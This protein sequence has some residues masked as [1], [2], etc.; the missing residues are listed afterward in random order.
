MLNH[1]LT[2][3]VNLHDFQDMVKDGNSETEIVWPKMFWIDRTLHNC[4]FIQFGNDRFNPQLWIF[5]HV[6]CNLLTG[7]GEWVSSHH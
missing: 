4:R 5:M 2:G 3:H 6:K 7:R 1:I